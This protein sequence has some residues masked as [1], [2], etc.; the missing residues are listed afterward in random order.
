MR[1][2]ICPCAC[3]W[4]EAATCGC[5]R[6]TATWSATCTAGRSSA[7]WPSPT[8]R[9]ACR[10]TWSP[11]AW[12]TAWSGERGLQTFWPPS[13]LTDHT[14]FTHFVCLFFFCCRPPPS[15]AI[16]RPGCGAHGIWN[17]W[18]RSPSP[19]RANPSSG[20]S[21]KAHSSFQLVILIFI[22]YLLFRSPR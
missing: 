15:L 21:R 11:E 20:I 2:T 18:G 7:R 10:S 14:R 16:D 8:S 6:W 3:Q 12:R 13:T 17:Q 4:A 19:S 22:L 9:R 1:L 5:G